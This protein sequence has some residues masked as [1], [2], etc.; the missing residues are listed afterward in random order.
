MRSSPSR[1]GYAGIVVAVLHRKAKNPTCGLQLPPYLRVRL[2]LPF[3]GAWHINLRVY[4]GVEK[5]KSELREFVKDNFLFG[6]EIHFTDDDSLLEN[7]IIDSTGVLELLAWLESRWQVEVED[8]E[9]RPENLDSI[10][11]VAR[12]VERKRGFQDNAAPLRGVSNVP[13]AQAS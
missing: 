11:R 5:V 1:I 12:F 9:L 7:G 13:L 8:H 6:R 4:C 3:T 2:L 10:N